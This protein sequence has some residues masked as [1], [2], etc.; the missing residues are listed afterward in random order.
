MMSSDQ[1]WRRSNND[2]FNITFLNFAKKMK[3]QNF[4][5]AVS[6]ENPIL[7]IKK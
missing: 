3:I 4:D 7:E 2:F 5:Y 1:T 6:S